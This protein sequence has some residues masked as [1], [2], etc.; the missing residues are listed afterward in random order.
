MSI[1]GKSYADIIS[2]ARIM[3][4]AL[5]RLGSASEDFPMG[6]G[7]TFIDEFNASREKVV[8]YNTEKEK[9]KADLTAKTQQM[10]EEMKNMRKMYS[11]AKKRVKQDVPQEKWEEFG[12][13]DKK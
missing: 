13:T 7:V 2:Q 5:N 1:W 3:I 6:L 8:A 12:I 4:D 11:E 9:M 10:D